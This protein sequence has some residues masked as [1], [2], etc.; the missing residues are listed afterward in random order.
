MTRHSVMGVAFLVVASDAF[1]ESIQEK[2]KKLIDESIE[3]LG[4][5]NFLALRNHSEK[6][7]AYSFHRERLAG[8]AKATIYF[9]YLTPPNPPELNGLYVRERQAFGDD[10]AWAVLFN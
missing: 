1:G 6:G 4:G 2:G 7:R 9:R 8:L 5:R 10:E 3:A